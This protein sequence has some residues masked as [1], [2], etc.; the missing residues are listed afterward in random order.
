MEIGLYADPAVYDVLH[1]QGTAREVQGLARIA[2][3]FV[4]RRPGP[5]T[6]L[7]PACGTG[8]YLL[9]AARRGVRGIGFDLNEG[10][11]R[12]AKERAERG[13][14]RTG[15]PPRPRFFVGDMRAFAVQVGASRVDLAFNVINTIRH[16]G[17]DPEVLAHFQEVRRVL[18]PGGVYAVGLTLSSYGM[19]F[20]S[21]DVWQ[22]RRGRLH[23]K[24]IVQFVPPAGARE[25]RA[26]SEMAHS[27]LVV[28]SGRRVEHRDSSYAL[29][30]Y[31]EGQWRSVVRRGGMRVA[32]LVDDDGHDLHASPSGYGVWVLAPITRW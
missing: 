12:Y 3:R 27:H 6:W 18:R 17:N 16:L 5:Q 28:T 32:G 4:V 8:R 15:G 21:E 31:S 20:P 26:R 25:I 23:V 24:Q 10:M 22:G 11:I 29:R 13:R 1:A 2:E 19:E 14:R 9:A 7:E 30:C